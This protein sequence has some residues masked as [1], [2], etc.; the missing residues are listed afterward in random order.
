MI[1]VYSLL[2]V[3][4]NVWLPDVIVR[5]PHYFQ[6]TVHCWV[7]SQLVVD[8]RLA[9]HS[10]VITAATPVLVLFSTCVCVCVCV[11]MCVSTNQ[12]VVLATWF[13][14]LTSIQVVVSML[15]RFVCLCVPLSQQI[16]KILLQPLEMWYRG[17]CYAITDGF[18]LLV[19]H[20]L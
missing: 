10:S 9:N 4:Q 14:V 19:S 2:V 6:A 16:S 5:Q 13:V 11:C 17:L 1:A 3:E 20:I 8:P 15:T 18:T 7:P 12:K